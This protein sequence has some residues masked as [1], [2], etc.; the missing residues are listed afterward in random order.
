MR[1]VTLM[2]AACAT[3]CAAT[4]LRGARPD[5][6][7]AL[8]TPEDASGG[9]ATEPFAPPPEELLELADGAELRPSTDGYFPRWLDRAA[10]GFE[11]FAPKA[12]RS[13]GE[14]P[15]YGAVVAGHEARI[16][17]GR[18]FGTPH[19][20]HARGARGGPAVLDA[21]ILAGDD[22]GRRHPKPFAVRRE[23]DASTWSAIERMLV[24][25]GMSRSTA[26]TMPFADVLV[27]DG[28]AFVIE[29][30]EGDRYTVVVRR[31]LPRPLVEVVNA[32]ARAAGPEF[33][34]YSA[35]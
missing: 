11:G 12:L 28:E 13:L 4:P 9:G 30:V 5:A 3:A 35:L 1:V 10:W 32:L 15:L 7:V 19:V 27:C 18:A 20:L 8:T 29:D 24:D 16:T 22:R 33:G 14:R 21:A 2:L 26:R 31:V 25:A 6:R 23:L 17:I 34:A